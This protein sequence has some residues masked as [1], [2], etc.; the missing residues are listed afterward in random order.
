MRFEYTPLSLT[1]IRDPPPFRP[2]V[3]QSRAAG[4][5]EG[6]VRGGIVVAVVFRY[7]GLFPAPRHLIIFFVVHFV[8]AS[9][10]TATV[11][12]EGGGSFERMHHETEASACA[13]ERGFLRTW[14]SWRDIGHLPLGSAVDK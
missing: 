4:P 9:M 11:T 13:Q 14:A 1:F 7:S 3:R 6:H 10:M 5:D 2:S 12:V 8:E